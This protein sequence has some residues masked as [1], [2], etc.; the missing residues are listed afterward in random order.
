MKRHTLEGHSALS[1]N[2]NLSMSDG[3]YD[4]DHNTPK[5]VHG[6]LN[7]SVLHNNTS[8]VIGH[9]HFC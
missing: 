2:V 5:T 9:H 6:T 3:V 8:L 4:D 7:S 1:V